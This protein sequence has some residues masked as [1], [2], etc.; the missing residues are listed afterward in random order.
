MADTWKQSAYLPTLLIVQTI[1]FFSF[2]SLVFNDNV[3]YMSLNFKCSSYYFSKKNAVDT[4]NWLL[5]QELRHKN[6]IVIPS[7]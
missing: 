6:I 4:N 7:I 2:L 3:T 1:A 5:W